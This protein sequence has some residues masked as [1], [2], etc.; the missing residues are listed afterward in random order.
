MS[1]RIDLTGQRFGRLTVIEAVG[2]DKWHH[3]KW[4]CRC[5]CGD[6]L[7]A[8]GSSLQNGNVKSCGCS[9]KESV[10][11]H[12]QCEA[13]AY[14]SWGSMLQRCYNSKNKRY[15]DWGGRGIT[16]CKRWLI[17]TNFLEDMGDRPKGLTI[18]RI[19]NDKGYYKENC[20]WA[21]R[22]IQARNRRTR[23]D[24][25][26]GIMGVHWNKE[27]QKYRVRITA[28]PKRICLGHFSNLP[29]AIETRKQAEVKYWGKERGAL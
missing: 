16:V 8:R 22:G 17:F 2:I 29:D 20:C 19:N 6:F 15:K 5:N 23:K 11:K 7:I 3:R 24:N 21:T 26:T 25:K 18:E 13:P 1:A 14:Y 12:G 10:Y 27:M 28:N 9:R 4:K